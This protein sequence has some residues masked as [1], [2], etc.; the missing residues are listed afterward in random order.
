MA[1]SA[2]EQLAKLDLRT[3]ALLLDIDGTLLD[4]AAKPNLVEVPPDLVET[5]DRL[6]EETAGALAFVSGREISALDRMFA[7]LRLPAVGGHGAEMRLGDGAVTRRVPDLPEPMR[8]RLQAETAT[9]PGVVTEDKGYSFTVHFRQA[10][11][12]END[13]RRI[14]TQARAAFPDIPSKLQAGKMVIELKHPDAEK[15]LGVIDLMERGAFAGRAPVFIGDDDTDEPV[16]S[17]MPEVGGLAFSVGRKY[18][19]L[20]GIFMSPADVRSAL[21]RLAGLT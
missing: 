16:F 11:A 20:A 18:P 8:R 10:P 3:H 19:G 14:M 9:L 6:S 13:V 15:K 5:L 21:R 7:P 2:P 4:I 1:T 12:R 17:L